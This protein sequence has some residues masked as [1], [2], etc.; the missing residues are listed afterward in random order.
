MIHEMVDK[1]NELTYN[2]VLRKQQSIT[3]L[4]PTFYDRVKKVGQSGG[5]SLS[6]QKGDVWHFKVASATHKGVKYDTYMRWVNMDRQIGEFIK[7]KRLWT[8]EGDTIDLRKLANEILYKADVEVY[9]SCPAF[10]YWGSSYIL[11]QR[12]AK[13]TSPENRPPDERNP[14][15][16]GALCKHSQL[17]F[18]VLPFYVTSMAAYLNKAFGKQIQSFVDLQK[19]GTPV[20][21]IKRGGTPPDSESTPSDTNESISRFMGAF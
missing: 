2:Q 8:K 10:L 7:D 20:N 17:L 13:F 3:S 18:D 12:R 6:S 19:K 15:Q 5:V 11:T 9:C 21:P 1:I 14:K 4:F 16:Y